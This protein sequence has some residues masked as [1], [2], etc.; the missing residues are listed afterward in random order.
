MHDGRCVTR[1]LYTIAC[2]AD[3]TSTGIDRRR[4]GCFA[5]FPTRAGRRW[6]ACAAVH[7][8]T[9]VTP[10]TAE[11]QHEYY[12]HTAT[13][14]Y[15]QHHAKHLGGEAA[16]NTSTSRTAEQRSSYAF[17]VKTLEGP[18]SPHPPTS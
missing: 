6:V 14:T 18:T 10:T 7:R 16:I 1:L 2:Q 4:T 15:R 17:C 9:L 13:G 8:L 12:Q 11:R 3:R 5:D